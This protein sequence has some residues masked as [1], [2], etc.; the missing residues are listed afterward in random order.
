MIHGDLKG[1]RLRRLGTSTLLSLP[2]KVNILIDQTGHA[3]LADFGLL[4]VISDPTNG[5]PSSS[6]PQG[7]TFRWM[8]PE[9]LDPKRFRLPRICPTV[10]SD[11]YA[12]GMVI[13]ETMSRRIPFHGC[14]DIV[15]LGKI[16]GD[17]R[18]PRERYFTDSLWKMVELCWQPQPTARPSV[19]EVLRC[20][21]M[22]LPPPWQA[23]AETE[24]SDDSDLWNRLRDSS[25]CKFSH[26]TPSAESRCLCSY[27]DAGMP[28]I[29]T[30]GGILGV[31]ERVNS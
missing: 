31:E 13:Y 29:S 26:S 12:L 10:S 4:K 19:E 18:P 14:H 23:S 15:A 28:R 21:E 25:S 17:D 5:L 11:C 3:R 9:L 7:G 27:V 16:L 6:T 20:L 24:G 8:S 22:E 2:I 30:R 1:V